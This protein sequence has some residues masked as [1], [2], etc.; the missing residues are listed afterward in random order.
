MNRRIAWL[1]LAGL[2]GPAC[3]S[4]NSWNPFL[5]PPGAFSLSAPADGASDSPNPAAFS[6]T[7]SPF[8]ATYTL[9]VSKS[10]TFSPMVVNQ[11][12]IVGTSSANVYL[13]YSSVYYWRVTAVN[14][15][16]A[17]PASGAPRSFT[18]GPPPDIA[19]ITSSLSFTNPVGSPPPP[20]QPATFSNP[21]GDNSPLNWVAVSNS[22]WLEVSPLSGTTGSGIASVTVSVTNSQT[23]AWTTATSLVNAAPGRENFSMVWTGKEVIVWGGDTG[24]ASNQGA[25][26]DPATDTWTR[27]TST[28]GAPAPRLGQM[29]TW[30]GSRMFVWGGRDTHSNI[31]GDGYLYDPVTDTWS[32]PISTTGA[33]TARV[34]PVVVSTG[35]EIIVWGGE[36]NGPVYFN[37]GAIY[38][39]TTDTWRPISSVNAPTARTDF[40]AVWTGTEMILFGGYDGT[41][42]VN[43]GGRYNPQLDTWGA[44]PST[45]GAPP[46]VSADGSGWDGTEMIVWGGIQNDVPITNLGGRYNP[47]TD[48]WQSVT[49]TGAPT[50]RRSNKAV[51]AGSEFIA[52]GGYSAAEGLIN[53]GKRYRPP[54]ALPAGT[55]NG[56]I[57]ILDPRASNSPQTITVTFTVTP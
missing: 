7:A 29:A 1:L 38:N 2:L 6:W 21:S 47:A 22:P 3:G 20:S 57:T 31:F 41:A 50:A 51:W 27:T 36:T 56:T 43:T 49:T 10:L 39:P 25:F 19:L 11:S 46:P 55:Y 9:Q 53:S 37:D 26:Y 28:V 45:V 33:P 8:A 14:A 12:G 4:T 35:T 30:T 17:T 23:E 48:S 40:T 5:P 16:G 18:T 44:P 34:L 42:R 13:D 54:I 52:W 32:G 15:S 24:S